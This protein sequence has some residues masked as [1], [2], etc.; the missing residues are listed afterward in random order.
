MIPTK[1]ND[2]VVS[3]NLNGDK[4]AMGVHASSLQKLIGIL[5]DL[6]SDPLGAV[7]REYST[8][9]IDSH[10]AA[11][12]KRPI[13]VS[14]PSALSP[15]FR[16]RDFG[17][18]LSV[19]DVR[20]I[21]SQYGASTKDTSNDF[22][23]M[24]GLGSKSALTYTSQFNVV[25]IKGGVKATVVV[26]RAADGTGTM[27]VVDTVSTTEGN[28]VEV[29]IPV[30]YGSEFEQKAR[31]FYS[32]WKPGTVLVNGA[33]PSLIKGNEVC[34]DVYSV[35]GLDRDYI[36][37]G[38]VAYPVEGG[39]YTQSYYKD[40][41]VVAYVP[42]G[43]V[44]FAPS[45]EALMYDTVTKTVVE[46]VK[47][48]FK[49][50]LA[51]SIQADIDMQPSNAEALAAFHKWKGMLGG[52]LPQHIKYKGSLVPQQWQVRAITFEPDAYRYQAQGV[53]QISYTVLLEK[54]VVIIENFPSETLSQTQKQKIKVYCDENDIDYS[55]FVIFGGKDIA[56]PWS[57]DVEHIDWDDI[58]LTKITSASTA[59][60]G[61]RGKQDYKVWDTTTNWWKSDND[62]QPVGQVYYVSPA[63][64]FNTDAL[65]VLTS[66]EPDAMIIM[67][68]MG[69]WK[70][71][72]R[73]FPTAKHLNTVWQPLLDSYK[74]KLTKDDL[75]YLGL[76]YYAKEP[77]KR[78]DETKI[79]D[80][81]LATFIRLAKSSGTSPGIAY[82][83]Q[84]RN[85]A[86]LIGR[87]LPEVDEKSGSP[88]S[89]YP[90]A[91]TNGQSTIMTHTYFYINAAFSAGI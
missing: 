31:K 27:E 33:E 74:S 67:L 1:T 76:D 10:I 58:R 17:V 88:L 21:Y 47:S 65:K 9:A 41:G 34:P 50:G 75:A 42:N 79:N 37:Q 44:T 32:F 61:V 15:Y 7:I 54:D 8:N 83:N 39:L 13:E 60:G 4:I 78:L 19:D 12:I 35:Q 66:V 49:A 82:Y 16:V 68:G 57:N 85:L 23:G 14:L 26:S 69:R 53:R 48:D 43:T 25:A 5:T 84:M 64:K 63:E 2:I 51:A 62:P 52:S 80:P 22:N 90:L 56:R 81:E 20:D 59:R 3:G 73:S 30:R 55:K 86:R 24:L 11:G 91:N 40:F 46:K 87:F 29:I 18:G 38:N 70:K 36:V 28:G 45:R 6:Y 71:F 77:L 89:K 72:L